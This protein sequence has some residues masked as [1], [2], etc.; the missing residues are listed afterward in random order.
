MNGKKTFSRSL[1]E[2]NDA[3]GKVAGYH[4]AASLGATWVSVNKN[5][6][7]V[8]LAYRMPGDDEDNPPRYLEVEVKR[9]WKQG[10]TFP[11]PDINVLYRKRKYFVEDATFLLVCGDLR[12]A[13]ALT[14][15]AILASPLEEVPNKYVSALEMFYKVPQNQAIFVALPLISGVS[16]I[17]ECLNKS[18]NIEGGKFICES[19][20]K[21]HLMTS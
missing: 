8:D 10:P 2:S 14:A 19:C 5:D 16:P 4:Y 13:L 18:F 21:P 17:C 20:Q 12:H 3:V 11:Y 6:Y 9:V 7:G 15:D 1:Y